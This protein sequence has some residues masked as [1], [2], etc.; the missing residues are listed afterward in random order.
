LNQVAISTL[1]GRIAT[2]D[3]A[4]S[5]IVRL[6][7]GIRVHAVLSALRNTRFDVLA[8][9]L[10]GVIQQVPHISRLRRLGLTAGCVG[11]GLIMAIFYMGSM[12]GFENWQRKYPEMEALKDALKVHSKIDTRDLATSSDPEVRVQSAEIFIA[13]R[14]GNFI[15]NPEAWNSQIARAS[16]ASNTRAE[17]ER[18]A[19]KYPSPGAEEVERARTVLQPMLDSQGNLSLAHQEWSENFS[20]LSAWGIFGATMI[21]AA[22]LSIGAAVLFRGGVLMRALGIGVVRGDG[23]DASRWRMLWRACIAWSWLPLAVTLIIPVSIYGQKQTIMG[24]AG[25]ALL[26]LVIW[27]V[28]NPGR[29]I[30]DRLSG[31]WLV[32][33]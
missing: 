7:L 11:P 16:M 18:I 31:T 24:L 25:L 9:Q 10:N 6:P 15:R 19:S 12:K 1:E 13:D 14:F 17:A 4:S 23:S 2:A 30:Q 26:S 29:S 27:S 32:P 20:M 3:E 5:R 28:A 21:W 33:R 8:E 22:F